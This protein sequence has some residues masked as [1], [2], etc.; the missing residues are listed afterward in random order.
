MVSQIPS[1]VPVKYAG[2]TQSYCL[3][4]VAKMLQLS[5]RKFIQW[6]ATN[7][8]IFKTPI[9]IRLGSLSKPCQFKFANPSYDSYRAYIGRGIF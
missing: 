3:S 7:H 9:P 6:L 1:K 5:P 4:T 8:Y 2:I